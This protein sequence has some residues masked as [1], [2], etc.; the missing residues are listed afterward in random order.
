MRIKTSL[1][2]YMLS[3]LLLAGF[4]MATFF[5]LQSAN[6][7]LTG[8]QNVVSHVMRDI[9]LEVPLG[10]DGTTQLLDFHVTDDWQKVPL[11]IRDEFKVPPTIE[12][13][14]QKRFYDWNYFSPPE[15]AYLLMLVRLPNGEPR[16]V[17]ETRAEGSECEHID[18]H[19]DYGLD[20]MVQI[21]L[22]GIGVT[23]I[24][25]AILL[26]ILRIVAR[27][28]EALRDWAKSL[29]ADRLAQP[30]PDFQYRELNTLAGIV[31]TSLDSVNT[32][33]QREQEFLGYASHELRTPISVIRSN[34]ALLK[35]VSP[36]PGGKEQQVRERIDRAS[37]TMKDMTE[38]L[39]WLSRD[40]DAPLPLE[41]VEL[42]GLISQL[43][44][45]LEYLLKGKP[46]EVTLDLEPAELQ[47]PVTA[48]RLMLCNLI[49]N[50]FQHTLSGRVEI[51]QRGAEVV[52]CNTEQ[53]AAETREDN[54]SLGFGLGLKLTRKLALRFDWPYRNEQLGREHKVTIC[55]ESD[56]GGQG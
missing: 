3:L 47:L 22:Y 2:V 38:T 32:A 48:A 50:A 36:D 23:V 33:L 4:G 20:P 18:V 45:E 24:F 19:E 13:D 29:S 17:S 39:L 53:A 44:Q 56:C 35:K 43:T 25:G 7:F 15:R 40:E 16:Y 21:A 30:V 51:H 46:V 6:Y 1:R 27:P 55:F 26:L 10:P 9:A 11:E 5:S 49:R 41:T 37:L 28:A 8:I 14:L 52:L 12:N 31:H 54:S 42:S 34:A